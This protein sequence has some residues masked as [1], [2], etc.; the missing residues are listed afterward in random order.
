[1]KM[2]P[3]LKITRKTGA[4]RFQTNGQELP[5][6]LLS[7]WQWS[8]SDLVGNALRGVLA[9]YIVA[10]AVSS[11]DNTRTEWG[12]FDIETPDGI[13]VEVKSAAYIQSWPQRRLSIIRF[14]VQETQG[15]DATTNTYSTRRKRQS[16]VYVFAVLAH[17]DQ[18]TINPLE[19]DQWDF[20][21]ISTSELTKAVGEQK[22]ISLSRLLEIGPRAVK[23]GEIRKAIKDAVSD[24]S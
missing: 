2:Y 9:E 1:M 3:A 23:F 19:L 11:N 12:A 15:C 10:I 14:G 24:R 17:E 6:D 20:Y 21:V 16:D 5:F 22:T 4:E 18:D 7:F 13:K 8:S